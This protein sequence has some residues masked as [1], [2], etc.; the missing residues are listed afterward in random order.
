MNMELWKNETDTSIKLQALTNKLKARYPE[1]GVSSGYIGNFGLMNDDRRWMVF[2]SVE[3]HGWGHAGTVT[4]FVRDLTEKRW[5]VRCWL[6]SVAVVVK[7]RR[8]NEMNVR[9]TVTG[10]FSST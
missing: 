8:L 6:N 5:G 10:R 9:G 3:R 4:Q 7:Q 2:T 1:L